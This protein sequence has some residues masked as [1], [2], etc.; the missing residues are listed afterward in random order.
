M[1]VW[2]SCQARMFKTQLS[3]PS[4]NVSLCILAWI[5]VVLMQIPS[6]LTCNEMQSIKKVALNEVLERVNSKPI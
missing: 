1:G 2:V 6:I 4:I 3:K 5:S